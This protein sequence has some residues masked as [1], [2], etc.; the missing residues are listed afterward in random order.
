MWY[1]VIA[2]I[3]L[4]PLGLLAPGG[5]FGEGAAWRYQDGVRFCAGRFGSL[6]GPLARLAA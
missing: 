2:L 5:A 6:E 3:V 1:V 4:C